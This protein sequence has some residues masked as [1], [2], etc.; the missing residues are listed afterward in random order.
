M[1]D[2]DVF[3]WAV[4]DELGVPSD[5]LRARVDFYHQAVVLNLYDEEITTTRLVS[6]MDV[7]HALSND[8]AFGTGLLPP[9][10]I[11]WRNTRAGPVYA[12]YVEPKIWRVALQTSINKA[13][14]RFNL[15]LPGLI[16]L[17]TP[18]REPWVYAVKKK[19]TK[20]TDGVYHAPLCNLHPNGRSCAGD[21]RYPTRS[22]D[23]VHSFFT[24][25]F[26]ASANLS[27]RSVKYPRN[28]VQLWEFLDNKKRFPTGD[29][30]PLGTIKDLL[31]MEM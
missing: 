15:P 8:L 19:P 13:A 25:F 6:A 23:I 26:T 28:I 2:T 1:G 31:Y 9:G 24:S 18:G 10:T 4:P 7:A 17:A 29:L 22:A 11:W 16:F 12:I 14:R 27:S 30:V 21:H 20:D 5:K 3:N